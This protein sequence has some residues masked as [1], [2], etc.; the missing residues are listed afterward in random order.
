MTYRIATLGPD[1]QVDDLRPPGYLAVGLSV[2]LPI[3]IRA[4]SRKNGAAYSLSIARPMAERGEE[5]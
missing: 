4:F 3:L 2:K 5:F 1:L